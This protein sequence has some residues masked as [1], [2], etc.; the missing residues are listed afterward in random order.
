[1]ARPATGQAAGAS[2]ATASGPAP[3][4]HSD[5]VFNMETG[6]AEQA[7]PAMVASAKEQD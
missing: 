7:K 5:I 2:G 6:L 3:V 4:K 1:M